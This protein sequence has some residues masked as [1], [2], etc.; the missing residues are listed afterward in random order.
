MVSG[1]PVAEADANVSGPANLGV[2][3]DACAA[4]AI[5]PALKSSSHRDTN[6]VRNVSGQHSD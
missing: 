2:G 3:S 1:S 6:Q 4:I 5:L